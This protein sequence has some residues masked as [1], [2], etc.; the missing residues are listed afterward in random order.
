MAGST[1]FRRELGSSNGELHLLSSLSFHGFPS[2]S[3]PVQ[4]YFFSFF[5]SK[6]DSIP[7]EREAPFC[8]RKGGGGGRG[9]GSSSD[10][11]GHLT[12]TRWF[13]L[14]LLRW[15]ERVPIY[16]LALSYRSLWLY[17][18][19][20]DEDDI[21]ERKKKASS[22]LNS[23]LNILSFSLSLYHLSFFCLPLFISFL[24][25][26]SLLFIPGIS[27]LVFSSIHKPSKPRDQ[28]NSP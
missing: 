21:N 19:S 26:P 24:S 9:E 7:L 10:V 4:P 8:F 3:N 6:E 17:Y 14:L 13:S 2:F 27:H 15:K 23:I 20:I 25:F 5:S 11:E 18:P 1:S 28:Q 22:R 12:G 16:F